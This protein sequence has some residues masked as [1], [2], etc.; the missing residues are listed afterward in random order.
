MIFYLLTGAVIE[1]I[2]KRL[3]QTHR[4]G[5]IETR[6]AISFSYHESVQ[7]IQHPAK[8][9]CYQSIYFTLQRRQWEIKAVNLLDGVAEEEYFVSFCKPGRQ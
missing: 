8:E 1:L 2:H 3:T 4:S 7:N 6:E 9:H 5:S